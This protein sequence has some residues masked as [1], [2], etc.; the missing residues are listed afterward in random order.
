MY[1]E[2]LM[3]PIKHQFATKGLCG[4]SG[5]LTVNFMIIEA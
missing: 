1:T 2:F 4:T 3:I 5:T